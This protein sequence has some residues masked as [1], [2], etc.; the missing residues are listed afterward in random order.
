MESQTLWVPEPLKTAVLAMVI[1][2][3]SQGKQKVCETLSTILS[4]LGLDRM[5]R[6]RKEVFHLVPL[7]IHCGGVGVPCF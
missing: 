5:L 4:Q 1:H 2:A 7:E 6:S 3:K